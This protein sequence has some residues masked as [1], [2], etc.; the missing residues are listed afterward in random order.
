MSLGWRKALYNLKV[1]LETGQ[2]VREALYG[3]PR[4]GVSNSTLP[5]SRYAETGCTGGSYL[6]QVF[7]DSPAA[8]AGLETGDVVTAINRRPVRSYADLVR[9][10]SRSKPDQPTPVDYVRR[11]ER[12]S[13]EVVLCLEPVFTGLI[14]PTE[15]DLNY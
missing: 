2:D 10:I 9:E 5:P 7:P 3:Y 1:V 12:R 8:L 4:M 14:N 11:G 13:T 15:A 6:R